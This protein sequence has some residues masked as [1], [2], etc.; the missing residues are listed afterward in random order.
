M[1]GNL[2]FLAEL[3]AQKTTLVDGSNTRG[4]HVRLLRKFFL[5]LREREPEVCALLSFANKLNEHLA[6]TLLPHFVDEKHF[7]SVITWTFGHF[8]LTDCSRRII[9]YE[10]LHL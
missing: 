2:H 7:D 9:I 3:D 4:R 8:D 10:E 5:H 6:Q 1:I